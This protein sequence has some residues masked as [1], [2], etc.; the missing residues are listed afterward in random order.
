LYEVSAD[1]PDPRRICE[2]F[3]SIGPVA[4]FEEILG[5]TGRIIRDTANIDDDFIRQSL[6]EGIRL[7]AQD[8]I[9]AKDWSL[10]KPKE[11]R[12]DP[13]ERKPRKRRGI[14]GL[15]AYIEATDT[16]QISLNTMNTFNLTVQSTMAAQQDTPFPP[17]P[18]GWTEEF[19]E[20]L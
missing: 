1:F 18:P 7:Y 17:N 10:F 2:R 12:N 11:F 6:Y 9:Y 15:E 19:P 16:P 4:F 14:A 3:S 8:I 13:F 5:S 20:D